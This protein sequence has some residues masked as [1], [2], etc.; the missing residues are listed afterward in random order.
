L[1]DSIDFEALSYVWG[2]VDQEHERI[3]LNGQFF[4]VGKNLFSAL[5]HIRDDIDIKTLWVDFICINQSDA[6]EKNNQVAHMRD[7]YSVTRRVLIWLGDFKELAPQGNNWHGGKLDNAI[8]EGCLKDFHKFSRTPLCLKHGVAQDYVLGALSF[9]HFLSQ[10][11]HLWEVPFFRDHFY[12]SSVLSELRNVM[13]SQWWSRV[14]VVQETV[15]PA[16]ATLLYG[17]SQIPW[18]MFGNAA[19]NYERHRFSCCANAL[20][21]V[22]DDVKDVLSDFSH[23]VLDVELIRLNWIRKQPITLLN[24]LWQFRAREAT[25]SRDKVFALVGLVR[26]WDSRDPFVADYNLTPFQVFRKVVH[27]IILASNSLAVLMGNTEKKGMN[28][29]SWIPDWSIPFTPYTLERLSRAHLYNASRDGPPLFN[30]PDDNELSFGI[31]AVRFST[32]HVVGDAMDGSDLVNSS[33]TF[34]KWEHLAKLHMRNLSG[35]PYSYSEI[36]SMPYMGGGSLKDA[37]LRTICADTLYSGNGAMLAEAA[38]KAY[39]DD[40]SFGVDGSTRDKDSNDRRW[41][42]KMHRKLKTRYH[43]NPHSPFAKAPNSLH[44]ISRDMYHRAPKDYLKNLESMDSDKITAIDHAVRSATM[45]RRFFITVDGF[46]GLGPTSAEIGDEV[47]ILVGG[48]TPF[49]LRPKNAQ[50]S[51]DDPRCFSLLGDCYV[52]GIMDGEA[53]DTH[54]TLEEMISIV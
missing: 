34:W 41:W 36:E 48:S 1:N 44:H 51:N 17:Q 52:H 49:L 28:L 9:V 31:S 32:I 45:H 22:A 43:T 3:L 12:R 30:F 18:T 39:Q 42:N 10:D 50:S 15:L 35:D 2:D 14:W 11:H 40:P 20:A 47:Y 21:E 25:D 5:Q 4:R 37:Y 53:M 16:T 38:N 19:K 33:E 46:I 6:Y 27:E 23:R 8:I 29:P 7:I 13:E 24:L 26:S 54:A